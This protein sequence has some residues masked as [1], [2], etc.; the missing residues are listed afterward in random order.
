MQIQLNHVAGSKGVL[1]E[2]RKE[3]F[4]DNVC[5]RDAYR[6]LLLPGGMRGHDHAAGLTLGSH[7]DLWTIIEVALHLTFGTLL[8]LIG[9]QVQARLNQRMVEQV[10]VFATGHEREPSHISE[11]GSVAI[12]PVEPQERTRRFELIRR[13]IA[14]DGCK[15][16]AQ[17]FPLSPVA[18]VP[19]TAEPLRTMRL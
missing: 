16:L 15:P 14:T 12:L 13:Q 5:T 8:G 11:H 4:V 9:G 2:V 19:E 17:F 3:E 18:S 6:T 10:I 1:R 7:R